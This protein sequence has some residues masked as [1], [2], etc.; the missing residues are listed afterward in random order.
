[1]LRRQWEILAEELPGVLD[2][3]LRPDP[4][5]AAAPTPSP[6]LAATIA[7][8]ET[9]PR[10]FGDVWGMRWSTALGIRAA[11]ALWS[12]TRPRRRLLRWLRTPLK[13]LPMSSLG[14]TLA[15]HRALLGL[16][17]AFNAVLMPRLRGLLAWLILLI[18]AGV[19]VLMWRVFRRRPKW[20]AQPHDRWYV[21]GAA[22][23][24][25]AGIAFAALPRLHNRVFNLPA[26]AALTHFDRHLLNLYTWIASAAALV[27]AWLI[28][29]WARAIWRAG[30]ALDGRGDHDVLGDVLADEARPGRRQVGSPGVRLP[31]DP[32]GRGGGRGAD[33]LHRPPR[34]PPPLADCR[35]PKGLTRP[36]IAPVGGS[37]GSS[38]S[39]RLFMQKR[40]PVGCGPSREHVAEVR[41]AAATAHLGADHP[42][43]RSSISSTAAATFGS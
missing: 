16:A 12:A 22:A 15:R 8:Y 24:F 38:S 28:L 33:H 29:C 5:P 32:V 25:A 13:P 19:A 39:D 41:T 20:R 27:A 6:S 18:A 31:S 14:I 37:S 7:D 1:M 2:A 30:G 35:V 17:L 40:C 36:Q 4:T 43:L 23:C 26:D 34:L 9:S 21:A 10:S 3:S 42:W 11:Y